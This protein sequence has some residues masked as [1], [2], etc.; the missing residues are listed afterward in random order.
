MSSRIGQWNSKDTRTR[1]RQVAEKRLRA[2]ALKSKL[3]AT[4]APSKRTTEASTTVVQSRGEEGLVGQ[5]SEPEHTQIRTQTSRSIVMRRSRIKQQ[6]EGKLRYFGAFHTLNSKLAPDVRIRYESNNFLISEFK[7]SHNSAKEV[8]SSIELEIEPTSPAA[9]RRTAQLFDTFSSR[10][11]SRRVI[12]V[13]GNITRATPTGVTRFPGS[14]RLGQ[15]NTENS[16]KENNDP[17]SNCYQI[18]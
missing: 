3:S 15:K 14:H 13:L 16:I 2:N 9:L 17:V 8:N 4:S 18:S 5:G 12:S 11:P 6:Q 1:L 10:R 7:K